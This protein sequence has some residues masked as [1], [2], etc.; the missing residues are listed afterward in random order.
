MA[1]V[2]AD[3]AEAIRVAMGFP[4]PVSSQL[5]GLA[6]AIVSHLS[7]TSVVSFAPGSVTGVAPLP[8]APPF[9]ALQT[10]AASNGLIV[11]PTGAVLAPLV[12]SMAGYPSVSAE[13]LGMC[14]AICTHYTT[15]SKVAFATGKVVGVCTNTL[16]TPGVFTGTATDGTLSGL[17]G[18]DL[19]DEIHAA[20]GFPGSTSAPLKAMANAITTYILANAVALGGVMTGVAPAP[21]GPITAG[22]GTGGTVS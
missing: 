10:G 18:D 4:L 12:Q 7:S 15:K 8:P 2:G 14:T 9:P 22:A 13:L 5:S 3:L 19:A 1:M 16:I 17:V 11:G 20:A 6:S 21:S